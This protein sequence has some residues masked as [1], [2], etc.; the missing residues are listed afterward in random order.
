MDQKLISSAS[1]STI[2]DSDAVCHVCIAAFD[3]RTKSA[4]EMWRQMQASRFRK[5]NPG[6][7]INTNVVSTPDAPEVIFKFIDDT[8]VGFDHS[9]DGEAMPKTALPVSPAL[10]FVLFD[11][12]T[13]TI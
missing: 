7:K 3:G 1:P 11:F 10:T 13:E 8:E 4:R 6:L 12:V 2:S 5:V 9:N